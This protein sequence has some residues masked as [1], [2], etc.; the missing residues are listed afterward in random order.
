MHLVIM[1]AGEGSRMQPLTNTVPK[2]LLKVCGKTLIEHN[3]WSIIDIFDEIFIIVKYKKEDFRAYFGE[4]FLGKKINY[5]DQIETAG[6]GAAILS[7]KGKI[8]GD[9]V[10]ISGDDL[11]SDKDIKKIANFSGFAT[12]CKSV[13][14][15]SDFG[16]FQKNEIG[17]AIR[18]IEKPADNSFW[19]LANIGIHKFDSTIF[20]DLEKIP[21]SPR[22]ELEITDL[23]DKYIQEEKYSVVEAD[24]KWLTI[25]Y[26][27]DLLK[28]TDDIIGNYSENIQNWVIIEENVVI[29]WKILAEKWAIIKSGTY[30]EGNVFI[31]EGAVIGP[32]TYIRENSMIG[33]NSKIGAFVELKNSYIGENTNIPH[34]SYIGDSV[35]GNFVNLGWGTKVANL[36]HDNANIKAMNKGKL[37]DTGRRKLGA[38]IGDGVHTGINTLIYPGRVLDTNS[39]TLPGEIIK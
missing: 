24:G 33:R 23:I 17:K 38:I 10:V 2:P 19:N 21:L 18:I 27:W 20:A 37:I 7:L 9:F 13:E 28:A 31:G 22:W 6:T 8:E 30:I 32:N 3:I 14:N 25:G 36:R 5:I 29:K 15:P 26:P 35:I 12:L 4:N 39:T 34:L 1:A 11:Y 16:I